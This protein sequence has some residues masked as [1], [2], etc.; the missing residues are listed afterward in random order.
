MERERVRQLGHHLLNR[1]KV[2]Y[3]INSGVGRLRVPWGGETIVVPGRGEL[4]P[5]HPKFSDVRHSV[6]LPLPQGEGEPPKP[7]LI[8][9]TLV[10]R[11]ILYTG[12]LQERVLVWDAANF[13][14]A[15]IGQDFE[16]EF[17]RRGLSWAPQDSSYE[18]LRALANEGRSRY[19]ES[20]IRD[21]QLVVFEQQ[22]K[23]GKWVQHGLQP[24][25]PPQYLHDAHKI[26]EV[27]ARRR[28]KTV[29]DMFLAGDP[30]ARVVVQVTGQEEALD[31]A[32]LGGYDAGISLVDPEQ[33]EEA[34]RKVA[35]GRR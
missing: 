15:K 9:G 13:I 27:A 17:G 28:G 31:P 7:T 26:L 33:D 23:E 10:V 8:P 1:E 5:P 2:F 6:I 35:G 25:P 20:Q 3:L 4:I 30:Y 24:P 32:K 22:V 21:A 12:E 19:E 14:M 34:P 11:D 16:E 29:T 18:E